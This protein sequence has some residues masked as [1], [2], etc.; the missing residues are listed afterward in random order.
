MSTRKD[1]NLENEVFGLLSI[2]FT[3]EQSFRSGAP[4]RAIWPFLTVSPYRPAWPKCSQRRKLAQK[5]KPNHF[6]SKTDLWNSKTNP[7]PLHYVKL[8]YSS[9]YVNPLVHF[10]LS[11][12]ATCPKYTSVSPISTAHASQT[13]P[14]LHAPRQLFVN[15]TGPLLQQLSLWCSSLM[16]ASEGLKKPLCL[17]TQE[18]PFSWCHSPLEI[19]RGSGTPGHQPGRVR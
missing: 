3:G 15:P 5:K 7:Q 2:Y 9:I 13:G 1:Q 18:A 6:F 17:R 10:L 12:V 19:H 8:K 4:S 14:C 11:S 16:S